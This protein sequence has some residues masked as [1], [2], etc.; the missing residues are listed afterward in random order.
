MNRPISIVNFE[1]CYLGAF[2]IGVLNTAFSWSDTRERMAAQEQVLGTWFMPLTLL[3]GFAI[4]LLIWY[5]IARRASVVA[6][7]IA[8]VFLVL[9]WIGLL[10][11]FATGNFPHGIPAV[12]SIVATILQT[13]AIYLLFKPDAEAW[14]ARKPDL[15][16]TFE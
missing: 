1:R 13:V 2:V 16:G 7:W 3:I 15:G 5:F 12:L 14:F 4:T 11:S 9:G 6:K 10:I 8:T